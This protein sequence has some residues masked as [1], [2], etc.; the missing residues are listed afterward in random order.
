MKLLS[1]TFAMKFGGVALALLA[2]CGP[3]EFDPAVEPTT[4]NGEASTIESLLTAAQKR[5]RSDV[6]KS[7]AAPRGITNPV[8]YAGVANHET[9]MAQCWSEAT[10]ACQGP[11]SADCGGGPVIAGS[12]DGACSLQQGGLGMFQFD[13]GTYSQTLASYGSGILS[14]SGNA[15]KGIDTIIAKMKA[16]PNTRDF[17]T[18]DAAAIAYLNKAK[19]GTTEFETFLTTMAW[20]YNGC[21]PTGCS[22]HNQRRE[23][24][25]QGVTELLNL[26]GT[27]YWYSS[28]SGGDG[29]VYAVMRAAT[30]TG[31]TEVH[32]LNRATNYQSFIYETG[33]ALHETGTDGSWMFR[34]G[35]YNNDGK[36]DLWAIAKNAVQTDV[37]IL[38]GATNFQ[39][40]LLH[41]ATGLHN[42]GTDL[43]WVFLVGDYNGDGRKDLYAVNKNANGK[44]DVHVLNGA[45]NFKT[46]LLHAVSGSA[47]IG[48]DN[49]QMLDLADFNN[50]GKLDLW[51]ISKAAT[52]SGTTEVHV[53]N[54]ADNFAT[55]ILHSSTA[56]GLTGTDGRWY[57]SVADYNGDGRPDLYAT[58]KAAT[59]SGKT[60]IHVL[61]GADGFK[62]FLL[63]SASA[64]GVTG[65]DHRW[66]F[67]L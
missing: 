35:D 39:S 57:F 1:K 22:A 9:G 31:T 25:R 48:T 52:G 55:Y 28:N 18:S 44:T 34:M 49:S 17:I 7:V 58:N 2:G 53:L 54:G 13:S 36:Q 67:D 19:P 14:V 10:W 21:T 41:A 6:V 11:S 47:N 65:T 26:F 40:F 56:L 8:V 4:G 46:F 15:S 63:H 29:N 16:C 12:G 5:S 50:D 33:T 62:T 23:D 3:A 38:D 24:Y 27:A 59:A 64:L 66:V 37:H 61:N 20:C 30:G 42:T 32:V 45:D 51:V 43:T 60:E